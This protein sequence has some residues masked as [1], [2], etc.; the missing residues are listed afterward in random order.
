[1]H[2]EAGERRDFLPELVAFAGRWGAEAVV[3]EEGYG[4]AMGVPPDAYLGAAPIARF[5][6]YDECLQQDSVAVVR[7]PDE[8]AVSQLRAGAVLVTMVHYPTRPDRVALLE[9]LG[10]RAVSLDAVV[11]DFG[12]RLVEHTEAVGWNGVHAA[13][14]EIAATHPR[15]ADPGRPP[16]RVTCLGAG[17]VGAHAVRAST[18]YGDPVLR[19]E[20][21]AKGVPGVEVTVVDHDLTRHEDYML[22]RLERTDLLIDATQRPDP[23][24]VVVP[25]RWLAALP[26]DAVILDLSV[27]PYDTGHDPPLVKGI[28]GIP[29]GDLDGWVFRPDDPAYDAID[30]VIDSTNRRLAL[31]CHAWPGL[32]PRDCMEVYSRQI[33][34]VLRLLLTKPADEWD[35]SDGSPYERAVAR[36]EMQR[37]LRAH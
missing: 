36:G 11:D 8:A 24:R 37:W 33:E 21:A 17:A 20:L 10:V 9:S 18:R 26:P 25:N 27:D 30:P 28:E 13:F 7:F 2:K 29:H 32:R 35:E 22:D 23:S 31:S 34:P 4:S 12:R 6:S 14:Q 1:M 3:L 16:L 5:G 15:F 19:E